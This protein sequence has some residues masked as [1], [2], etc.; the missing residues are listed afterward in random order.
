MADTNV[1]MTHPASVVKNPDGTYSVRVQHTTGGE[2]TTVNFDSHIFGEIMANGYA[3]ILNGKAVVEAK[4][5]DFGPSLADATGEVKQLIAD[6]EAEAQKLLAAAKTE[7]GKIKADAETL[8]ASAK[9]EA[10]T[11]KT[12]ASEAL[13]AAKTE[14][15]KLLNEARAEASKLLSQAAAKVEPTAPATPVTPPT[16]A[17][18]K[19]VVEEE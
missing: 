15:E 19:P 9:T 7:A 8:V 2:V 18:S 12:K 17:A 13:E 14:A 5:S 3:D 11:L 10:G 16:A 1:P 4:L 6:A